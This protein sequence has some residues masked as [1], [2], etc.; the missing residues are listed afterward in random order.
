MDT[1]TRLIAIGRRVIDAAIVAL[2]VLVL[3]GLFL[4]R[5]VP[6]TGRD[7]LIIGGGSMQP[8]IPMGA[9]IVVE[10]VPASELSV[11]DVVTLRVGTK[12]SI[13]THRIVRLL[14]LDGQPYIETK[15]DANAAPD[16]ATIPVTAVVGRVAWSIP[17]AGYLLALLS[18]PAGVAFVIGLGITLVLVAI[19]LDDLEQRR[20]ASEERP[21]TGPDPGVTPV[22]AGPPLEGRVTYHLAANRG[23]N[24]QVRPPGR[25]G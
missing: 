2:V 23:L 12:P 20:P 17:L 4:G 10:P 5:V 25:S 16:G 14:T 7:T 24:P 6:L 19:L 1:G 22:Y 3:I 18:I 8:A 9:A 15:G 13:F 21:W 11:G